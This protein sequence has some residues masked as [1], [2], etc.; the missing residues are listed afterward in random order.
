M[1]LL[2]VV[3]I[4]ALMGAVLAPRIMTVMD[5]QRR[6]LRTD[7]TSLIRAAQTEATK[8][9]VPVHLTVEPRE[10]RLRFG[11]ASMTLPKGWRMELD[12]AATAGR[13]AADSAGRSGG[14]SASSPVMTWSPTGLAST[15]RWRLVDTR[16]REVRVT[17]SAVEGVRVE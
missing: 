15:S 13:I 12:D 16:G 9:G 11:A 17:A 6:S 3:A 14:R 1:E 2:V 5:G 8:R 7:V 10:N 4:L